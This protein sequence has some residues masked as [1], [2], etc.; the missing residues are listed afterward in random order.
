MG[1]EISYLC[2]ACGS[3][4]TEDFFYVDVRRVTDGRSVSF[5]VNKD[6]PLLCRLCM[7]KVLMPFLLSV[8]GSWEI[9]EEEETF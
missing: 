9:E 1:R 4:C 6:V 7:E 3:D 8:D 5:C 2:D